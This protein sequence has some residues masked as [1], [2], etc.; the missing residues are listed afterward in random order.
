MVVTTHVCRGNFR[1]TWIA[2]GGYEPVA[3]TCWPASI[4]TAIS[5][6]T[7]PTA[8]AASSRCAS[9]PRATRSWWSASSPRRPASSRRRTTSSA[10]SRRPRN[11]RRSSSSPVAAMRLRLDRGRQHPRR[12]GA[13]GEARPR[14]RDRQGGVGQ[15]SLRSPSVCQASLSFAREAGIQYAAA[16]RVTPLSLEYWIARSSRAMTPTCGGSARPEQCEPALTSPPDRPRPA[17]T[18][19]TTAPACSS[20]RRRLRPAPASASA[21]PPAPACR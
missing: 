21:A 3:E 10:G 11:S 6:N 15:V 12:G 16:S 13:V 1:S 17:A 4:T 20:S 5:S 7:T 8:P 2:S 9:C 18:S 19:S 14:G